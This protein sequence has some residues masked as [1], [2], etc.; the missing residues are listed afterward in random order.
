MVSLVLTGALEMRKTVVLMLE[1][2]G[3]ELGIVYG[4]VVK[5]IL[6]P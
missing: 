4:L 1:V 6:L 5:A 3:Q 2:I